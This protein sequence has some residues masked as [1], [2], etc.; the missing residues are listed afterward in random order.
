MNSPILYNL[1]YPDLWLV[2]K[3]IST[4]NK[5]CLDI[6]H[7]CAGSYNLQHPKTDFSV[8][9]HCHSSNRL[10]SLSLLSLQNVV[11]KLDGVY[12]GMFCQSLIIF[13]GVITYHFTDPFVGPHAALCWSRRH[14][15]Q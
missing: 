15:D 8:T 4:I 12:I 2:L 11:E 3:Y 7:P 14:M 1:I 9:I 5:M 10:I 6:L 13:R